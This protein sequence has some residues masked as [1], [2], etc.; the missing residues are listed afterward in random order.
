MESLLRFPELGFEVL[1]LRG[2]DQHLEDRRLGYADK[3]LAFQIELQLAQPDLILGAELVAGPD[4]AF[5]RHF[6]GRTPKRRPDQLA[7]FG[8]LAYYCT[9][10][11]GTVQEKLR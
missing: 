10:P 9:R 8:V 3:P 11:L 4:L 5:G 6:L 1:N 7:G 2:R